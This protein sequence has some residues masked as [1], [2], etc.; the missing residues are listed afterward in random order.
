[1]KV[2]IK[3]PAAGESVTE[4]TVAQIFKENGAAVQKEEELLELET[5]KVNQVIYSPEAGTVNLTVAVDDVVKPMQVIG[6]IDFQTSQLTCLL[7]F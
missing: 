4:A 7:T 3:V 5:D 2:E 1:M 6:F